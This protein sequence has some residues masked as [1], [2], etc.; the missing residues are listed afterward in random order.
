[1]PQRKRG[2]VEQPA[3]PLSDSGESDTDDDDDDALIGVDDDDDDDYDDRS[4]AKIEEAARTQ[5][6]RTL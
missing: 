4:A 5:L 6:L 3:E 2:K 1:V